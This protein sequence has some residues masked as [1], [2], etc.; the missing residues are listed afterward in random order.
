MTNAI[1]HTLTVHT[2]NEEEI[3]ALLLAENEEAAD[4]LNPDGGAAT[5]VHWT[6]REK[7]LTEFSRKHPGILFEIYC[8]DDETN[9]WKEYYQDG[10]LQVADAIITYRPF[11]PAQLKPYSPQL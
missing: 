4:A 6:D 11:D 5:W 10:L 3:I 1:W 8:E 9:T 2:Q 7:D